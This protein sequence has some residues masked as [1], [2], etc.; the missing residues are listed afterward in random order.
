M[1]DRFRTHTHSIANHNLRHACE[2]ILGNPEF[3]THPA[4]LSH[5]HDYEGGLL[6]H[7]VEVTDIALA[8]AGTATSRVMFQGCPTVRQNFTAPNTDILIAAC[9]YHDFMKVREYELRTFTALQNAF[10]REVKKT[11]MLYNPA[12]QHLEP[13]TAW[14]KDETRVR[15]FGH[16]AHVVD[17]AIEFT[18]AARKHGVTEDVIEAVQ[19]CILA[20]HGRRE[21]GSPVE[22]QTIEAL[23]LSQADMLSS[24]F[25][26][27][28]DKAP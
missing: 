9:L 17:S 4:S 1:K 28:K 24:R 2:E 12:V 23:I 26:A 11:R 20:H 13:V 15:M 18:V 22:P 16:H 10:E 5:H 8:A 19:H 7:T 3:F 6:A 14:V 21:W 27:T 25:G